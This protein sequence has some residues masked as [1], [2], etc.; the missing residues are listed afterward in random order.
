MPIIITE[1]G[2]ETNPVYDDFKRISYLKTHFSELLKG[3]GFLI[4]Q[5]IRSLFIGIRLYDYR[6]LYVLFFTFISRQRYDEMTSFYN[7]LL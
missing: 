1:N 7:V 4:K 6:T 3:T 2:I 5:F